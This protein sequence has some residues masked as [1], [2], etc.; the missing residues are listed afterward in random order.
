MAQKAFGV[1]P[2]H[3]LWQ[4]VGLRQKEPVIVG[5]GEG[6]IC[7]LETRQRRD[8]V[9]HGRALHPLGI[10][11]GHAMGHPPA[12]VVSGD[13]EARKAQMLHQLDLIGR[14]RAL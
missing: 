3:A 10:V 11:E 12:A 8:D 6:H 5:H 14:H 13:G 1:R 2:D 4:I 9:E 7:P